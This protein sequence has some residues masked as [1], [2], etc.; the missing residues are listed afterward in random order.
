M[1]RLFKVVTLSNLMI[2]ICKFFLKAKRLILCCPEDV[3]C[4]RR[5][6]GEHSSIECCN[7]C[8]A[9]VCKECWYQIGMRSPCLPPAA[10]ANDM[11]IYYALT[12]L[13]TQQATMMEMICAS[14]CITSMICFTFEKETQEC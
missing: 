9:P 14:V 4:G 6:G 11:M 7:A 1:H 2:C 5:D 10:L 13:Y 3:I 12:I 8:T